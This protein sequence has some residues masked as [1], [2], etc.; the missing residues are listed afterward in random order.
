MYW[1]NRLAFGDI[2]DKVLSIWWCCVRRRR[3]FSHFRRNWPTVDECILWRPA[4]NFSAVIW[5]R[6]I[7]SVPFLQLKWTKIK[8]SDRK[9][10]TS[11]IILSIKPWPQWPASLLKIRMPQTISRRPT[12]DSRFSRSDNN[13]NFIMSFV[14]MTLFNAFIVSTMTC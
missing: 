14:D 12:I 8:L 2:V 1:T 13:E 9:T 10:W 6:H 3:T 5:L 4:L 11:R 7:H